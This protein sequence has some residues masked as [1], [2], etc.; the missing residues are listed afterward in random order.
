MISDIAAADP[1]DDWKAAVREFCDRLE[2]DYVN[3]VTRFAGGFGT[4]PIARRSAVKFRLGEC[5]RRIGR[6]ERYAK[7]VL[8]GLFGPRVLVRDLSEIESEFRREIDP[9]LFT[10]ATSSGQAIE[11]AY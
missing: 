4:W 11:A 7:H 9:W 6:S 1:I 8:L 5:G 10:Q 3:Q 2:H